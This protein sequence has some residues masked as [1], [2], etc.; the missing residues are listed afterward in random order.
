MH[1]HRGAHICLN[2][3]FLWVYT[4]EWYCWIIWQLCFLRNLHTVFHSGC[5]N[6]HSRQ[7]CIWVPL[8]P[9]LFQHLLFLDFS[10]MAILTR[11]RSYLILM[12]ICI[13]III[14][15]C[16]TLLH[17]PFVICMLSLEKCL[18]TSS[19]LFFFQ[20]CCFLDTQQ[21]ELLV[22]FGD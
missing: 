20:L 2:Y 17:V 10:M 19:A 3:S 7:Q 8:S 5:S 9:N 15:R 22:Y 18:F 13:S 4:Q 12:L 16:W 21:Y 6:L 11:V 1:E 14:H